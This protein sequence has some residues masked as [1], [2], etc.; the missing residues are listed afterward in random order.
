MHSRGCC[1]LFLAFGG[2]CTG[3]PRPATAFD[4]SSRICAILHQIHS[5]TNF[6]LHVSRFRL[7]RDNG[8]RISCLVTAFRRRRTLLP[9]PLVQG[10]GTGGDEQRRG[11]QK[12]PTL[13]VDSIA[14]LQQ[15][16]SLRSSWFVPLLAFP[17]LS[18]GI[19]VHSCIARVDLLLSSPISCATAEGGKRSAFSSR[20]L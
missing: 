3:N 14:G 7:R 16:L 15:S 20:M 9:S 5:L 18:V 17:E 1:P 2:R 11:S 4:I 8:T 6:V 12:V 10:T 19:A 13:G